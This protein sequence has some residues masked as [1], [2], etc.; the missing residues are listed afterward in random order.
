MSLLNFDRIYPFNQYSI[1]NLAIKETDLEKIKEVVVLNFENSGFVKQEFIILS[2][3]K[4][5]LKNP[6]VNLI[7]I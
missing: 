2:N 3:R 4:N 1:G 7:H 6:K 5:I